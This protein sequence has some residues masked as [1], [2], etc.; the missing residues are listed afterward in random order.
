MVSSQE[1]P[2]LLN[3]LCKACEK[4]R[5]LPR[6]MVIEE[7]ELTIPPEGGIPQCGGGFGV[8]YKG[9]HRGRAVAIKVMQLY[10]SS[11][12]DVYLTVSAPLRTS[13]S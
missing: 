6:T 11:N 7:N 2:E 12:L 10:V 9:V 13:H 8:V 3:R 4:Q 1:R 5:S